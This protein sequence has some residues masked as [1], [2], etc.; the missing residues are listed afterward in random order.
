MAKLPELYNRHE[1]KIICAIP[2]YN[3]GDS[4]ESIVSKARE[5]VDE[6]VVIDDGSSD[7]TAELAKKAGAKVFKH[8]QN[9]GYGEAIKTS[10]NVARTHK[11]DVLVTIDGDGQHD[12][13]E[14]PRLLEPILNGQADLVIGNRFL[15][16]AYNETMPIYRGFGIRTINSVWNFGSKVKVSDTQSG[17][18][19]YNKKIF[20]QMSL[21]EKGM[22]VSIEVLEKSRR[23]GAIIK[24]VPISCLY[25]NRKIHLGAFKHGIGVALSVLRIRLSQALR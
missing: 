1:T 19:A 22:G 16:S 14:I 10:F 8:D 18:R 6:V 11:A 2:C 20:Q 17:F 4:I 9:R 13:E 5:V 3:T 21:S 23:N 25:Y 24:E 12:P 7:D 15:L